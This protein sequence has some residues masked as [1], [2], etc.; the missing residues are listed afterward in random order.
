MKE[1]PKVY[2]V[3]AGRNGEDEDYVLTNDLAIIGFRE[4]PSLEEAKDYDEIFKLVNDAY[5]GR[6]SQAIANFARQLFA[7]AVGMREGDVV[8]LPRKFT[9]QIAIGCVTGPYRYQ[10]VNDLLRH[11]RPVQWLQPDLPRTT[12]EQDLLYSFGAFMTVCNISRNDAARRVA[13]V[14]EGKQ[15]PGPSVSPKSST[16][17]LPP[18]TEESEPAP[19]LSQMAHDQI[20]SRIQSRF[21]GHAMARLVDAV[22]RADGWMTKASPPGPDEAS[23]FLPDAAH[24]GWTHRAFACRSSRRIPLRMSPCTGHCR[25]RCRPSKRN[26]GYSSVGAAS[27]SRFCRNRSRVTSW[28]VCGKAVISWEP[29]IATM[30]A[31]QR[32][33][34]RS[35]R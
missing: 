31:Y 35:C 18:L 30:N 6:K 27:T 17:T 33:S 15:D 19:D 3:R 4:M 24:W 1:Q 23:I 26:R 5:P 25:A 32:K 2:L 11:A 22:L 28:S 9:S 10:R 16:S 21:T 8:V 7:F 13:A 14:L 29:S 12:F 34:R 20:V